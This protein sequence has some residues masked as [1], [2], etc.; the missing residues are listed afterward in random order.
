MLL[1]IM[2]PFTITVQASQDKVHETQP[3]QDEAYE[4][5]SSQN[6]VYEPMTVDYGIFN[7]FQLEEPDYYKD[8]AVKYVYYNPVAKFGL[9]A[10]KVYRTDQLNRDHFYIWYDFAY[11]NEY[12]DGERIEILTPYGYLIKAGQLE[13]SMALT[14][15]VNKHYHWDWLDKITV[16][17]YPNVGSNFDIKYNGYDLR[18]GNTGYV[19]FGDENGPEYKKISALQK[20]LL[21]AYKTQQTRYY[22]SCNN[23]YIQD[24]V[25]T[26]ADRQDPRVKEVYAC[27]E[28]GNRK[29]YIKAG[30]PLY[31]KVAFTEPIRFSDNQANHGDIKVDITGK[32]GEKF[33]ANLIKLKDD[34]LLFK[35]DNTDTTKNVI[36]DEVN[37]Y[38]FNGGNEKWWPL[39]DLFGIFPQQVD[40]NK[41]DKE[42]FTKS[43]TLITDL[44]GNPFYSTDY[45]ESIKASYIDGEPPYIAEIEIKERHM[46]NADIKVKMEKIRGSSG[47]SGNQSEE[48][49]LDPS[50]IN[51]GVGDEITYTAKFNELLI[52]NGTEYN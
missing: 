26:F 28:N 32:N 42:G 50:D 9:A 7:L 41:Y 12:V 23:G 22:C 6:I 16:F 10:K 24:I 49:L 19:R 31:L 48:E 8:Y 45:S 30:D 43:K 15:Y 17:A 46:N 13:I 27:D 52:I 1:S 2:P 18:N 5:Q 36:L 25:V 3:V 14:M 44:A 38:I 47:T 21:I 51:A 4:T 35:L 39:K 20:D 37:L 29:V 40:A 33:T 34:Y 11:K